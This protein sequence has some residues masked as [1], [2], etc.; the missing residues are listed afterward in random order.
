M[1]PQPRQVADSS[2]VVKWYVPEIGSEEAAALLVCGAELLAP[3]LLTAEF[4]N[5]L[6]KKVQRGELSDQ[7]A[8]EILGLFV[9][10]PPV[11]LVA[12]IDY[13][14]PAL[15]LALTFGRTLYDSLYLALAL[16]ENT[17]LITADARFVNALAGTPL[18][19]S[20]KLLG[21]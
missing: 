12:S 11:T 14:R 13:V 16:A 7:E 9:E 15:E 19:T 10:H 2:V 3:D 4:G 20:I 6:W 17:R 8:Q 18:E 5:V 21:S 1:T